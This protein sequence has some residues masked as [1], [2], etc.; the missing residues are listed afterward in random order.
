MSPAF[1]DEP[2]RM[3][4]GEIDGGDDV[5]GG[6]SG[7]RIGA[8][9]RTPGTHPAAGLRERNLIADIEWVFQIGQCLA[10]GVGIHQAGA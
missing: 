7:N 6:F 9:L 2:K 8:R 4:A 10:V 3:F 5:V 1:D